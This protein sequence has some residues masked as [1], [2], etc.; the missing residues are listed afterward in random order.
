MIKTD[1][2]EKV[3]NKNAIKCAIICVDEI[4]NLRMAHAMGRD[5]EYSEAEFWEEL[6]KEINKIP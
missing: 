2:R 6:K 3:E 4:L 5:G 1:K